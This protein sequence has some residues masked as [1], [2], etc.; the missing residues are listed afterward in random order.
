MYDLRNFSEPRE[1]FNIAL[2][3]DYSERSTK[4]YSLD[5]VVTQF[6]DVEFI[7]PARF[8]SDGMSIPRRSLEFLHS[9]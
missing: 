8:V 9:A 6:R 5:S 4:F 2:F 3:Y 1:P 7:I